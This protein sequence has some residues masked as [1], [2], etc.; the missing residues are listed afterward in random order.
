MGNR[1]KKEVIEMRYYELPPTDQVIALT[2]Q[3]WKRTYGQ[4][5]KGLHVHNLMEI[6]I[7]REGPGKMFLEEKE[8]SYESDEAVLTV[9]PKNYPHTT[10]SG[11]L[12]YWEYI[13]FDP[14]KI[15]QEFFPDNQVF[16]NRVLT[17]VNRS[18]LFLTG[19]RQEK[20]EALV[21]AILR[22]AVQRD[23]YYAQI[24]RGMLLSLVFELARI[25]SDGK[26]ENVIGGEPNNYQIAP[27]LEYIGMQYA[28]TI[29]IQELSEVCHMS[30]SHFRRKFK[31]STNTT[32]GEYITLIRVQTACEMMKQ[33][34]D[35][36]E[37][38]AYKAGFGTV[39][40]FNRSFH[41][42]IGSSPYQWKKHPENFETHLL[43]KHVTIRKGW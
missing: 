38:I 39:S 23:L 40:S 20:I 7:H 29:R 15:L 37:T 11:E 36:M 24:I 28:S 41:Q 8:Y 32:P 27:A 5:V 1:K 2:G 43:D 33:T 22:E 42:L 25:Q 10:Y 16:C 13:F 6:G 34:N 12:N 26:V 30:E 19:E 31:E 9:L 3:P 35:S 21:E 18:A 14:K 4:E 17:S